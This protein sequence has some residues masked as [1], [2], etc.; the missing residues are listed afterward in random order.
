MSKYVLI[1]VVL[2]TVVLGYVWYQ[3]SS[4]NAPLEVENT[5][6]SSQ[7]ENIAP[8]SDTD[9]LNDSESSVEPEVNQ[10]DDSTPS[11]DSSDLSNEVDTQETDVPNRVT[12]D[13]DGFNYEYD[14]KQIKV[15]KGDIVTIN[16]KST[17]GFHDW[18]VDEFDAATERINE[19]DTTSVTFTADKVGTFQ[20][21]CS[22]G[23]HRQLGMVGYIIVEE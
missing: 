21:Y 5:G 6:A 4:P 7:N 3:S 9:N 18:V 13:M 17:E 15:K 16:L 20:Y 12:I 1:A 22:V 14:V 23:K 19:G 10:A 8:S 11:A 2:V